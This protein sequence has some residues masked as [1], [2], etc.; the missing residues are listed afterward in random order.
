MTE[1]I[2]GCLSLLLNICDVIEPPTF[3]G[4]DKYLFTKCWEKYVIAQQ[5]EEHSKVP[6]MLIGLGKFNEFIFQVLDSLD[7][8][9]LMESVYQ[10]KDDLSEYVYLQHSNNVMNGKK[11]YDVMKG[12][13]NKCP[14]FK[15]KY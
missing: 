4:D 9:H 6:D 8:P 14:V 7:F 13:R 2:D 3:S 15:D 5:N 1:S 12:G 10:C 11:V